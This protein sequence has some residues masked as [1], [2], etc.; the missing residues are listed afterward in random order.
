MTEPIFLDTNVLVYLYD[1][2]DPRK[3]KQAE[4]LL[5]ETLSQKNVVISSQVVVEFCNVML[6]KKGTIMR[7]T[8]LK[9]VLLHVLNPKLAHMP[10][11]DFYDRSVQLFVKG[12]INFYDALIVQAAIDLNCDVIY[13]ED[14]QNGQK[15]GK[16][17]VI[18]PFKERPN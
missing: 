12:S 9:E 17:E 13:S 7:D 8:D 11:I 16:L 14:L 6:T 15:F 3:Q 4:K 5:F 18:N 10:S 1:R 2:R